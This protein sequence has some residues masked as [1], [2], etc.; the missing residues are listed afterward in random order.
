MAGKKNE[1][2]F[3]N[4]TADQEVQCQLCPH[5]CKIAPSQRGICGVRENKGGTLYSLNYGEVTSAAMDPIEKKPLYHFY[6]GSTTLSLGTW[7]CNLSCSFC[8][9]WRIS[10]GKPTTRS[11]T[12]EDIVKLAQDKNSTTITFTY[13]EPV[14]WTEFIMDVASI[15]EKEGLGIIL[16]TNGYISSKPLK[17]LLPYL[18]ACNIDLKS[19]TEKFYKQHCGGGAPEPVKNTI[20]SLNKAGVHLEVT[21][22][23]IPGENDN[24]EE[25]EALC[26]FLQEVDPEIP[27][28]LSRYFPRHELQNPKTPKNTMT[29]S[30]ELAQNYLNYVYLGNIDHPQGR[31]TCCPECSAELIDRTYF[32]LENKLQSGKCPKCGKEIKGRFNN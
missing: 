5:Y 7:G 15:A 9:N 21:N 30:F 28:H 17:K 2:L 13:S 27:L 16:V 4:K 11:Y 10:Q 19:V 31:K 25:L 26:D 23:L 8:Q 24:R 22:L 1:A 20:T 12:P 14:V 29:E 6:P 32:Q 3:Y 18:S